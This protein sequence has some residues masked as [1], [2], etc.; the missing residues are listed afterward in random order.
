MTQQKTAAPRPWD[1]Q[2]DEPM[3]WWSRFDQYYRPLGAERSLL[4]AYRG[5]QR[6]EKGREGQTKS[7]PNSWRNNAA[8]WQWEARA[9][10]WDEQQAQERRKAELEAMEKSRE[11]RIALLNATFSRAFEAL[12][13]AQVANARLGEV[14]AAIRMVVQELR[15]EYELLHRTTEKNEAQ[16][17]LPAFDNLDEVSDEELERIVENL[18][19]AEALHKLN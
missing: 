13:S 5:W 17:T 19:T 8:K 1:R 3:R 14:T 11:Q 18:L 9:L 2:A 4:A 10:A 7:A 12:R 16:D 6:A 15:R